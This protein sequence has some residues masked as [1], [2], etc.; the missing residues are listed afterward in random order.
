MRQAMRA[1]APEARANFKRA[2]QPRGEDLEAFRYNDC[3]RDRTSLTFSR[4]ASRA[5]ARSPNFISN[6]S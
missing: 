4:T 3:Q 5:A 2:E 1:I 6:S